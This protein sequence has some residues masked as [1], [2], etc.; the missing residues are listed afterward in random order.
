VLE[1]V[2]LHDGV[3]DPSDAVLP[4]TVSSK[5]QPELL[6]PVRPGPPTAHVMVRASASDVSVPAPVQLVNVL[7]PERFQVPTKAAA[8][9]PVPLLPELVELLLEPPLELAEPLLEPVPPLPELAELLLEPPLELAEPLLE[10]VPL[11]PELAELLL[12]LVPELAVPPL[13]PAPLLPAQ[14]QVS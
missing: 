9:L 10:P 7:V 5:S 2:T 4:D 14:L 12:E 11:L 6:T 1:S 3:P 13:E 8:A